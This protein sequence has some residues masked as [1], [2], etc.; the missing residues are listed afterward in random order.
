MKQD[1]TWPT[2]QQ[3]AIGLAGVGIG[4]CLALS[5]RQLGRA[6]SSRSS[7]A[8]SASAARSSKPDRMVRVERVITV[9]KPVHTVYQYWRDF[10]NLPRFMRHLKSIEQLDDNRWR[11]RAKGPAGLTVSW[12]AE[13]VQDRQDEW[14]AWRSV[15]GSDVQNSGSVGFSPAPGA[16]GTEVRVTLEYAPPAGAFGRTLA[17]LFGEEPE[18]QIQEDLHR[19]KQ[20]LE[21]GEIAVSDGPSLWRAAQPHKN[22]DKLKRLAGVH[23]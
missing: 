15:E 8:R 1:E 20:L 19:F 22:P 4:T 13:I 9:N 11:W 5:V 7:A 3:L 23:A 6:R 21:T 14:I 2:S 10:Q 16:R 17:K 18:Q 12:E